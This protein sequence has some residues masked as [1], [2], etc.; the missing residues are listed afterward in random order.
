MN[1]LKSLASQTAVYGISSILA[2]LLNYLLVPLHTLLFA[3][4][5]FGPVPYFYALGAFLLIIY[6]HGMETTFF[7][8]STKSNDPKSYDYAIT[9]VIIVSLVS[10]VVLLVSADSLVS[11]AG[12]AG[13]GWLLQW[14]VVIIFIDAVTAIPFAKMR[15]ENKARKF[16]ITKVAVIAINIGL[17]LL[18]LVAAPALIKTG[19]S[20]LLSSVYNP[21]LGIGYIFLSNLTANLFLLIFLWPYFRKFTFRF[22]MATMRPMLYYALP[23]LLMG[24]AGTVS[25]QLDKILV[26]NYLDDGALGVYAQTFKLAVFIMLAIQAFRY[27]GEPFF[28]SRAKDKNAP[29]LFADVL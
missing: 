28:F 25:E 5:E 8:F 3:K 20:G 22:H 10:S 17:Q 4:D 12:Y 7:R 21:E 29:G 24:L 6:T 27:A 2:R 11:L 1:H 9:S 19:Y 14:L 18:F 15:L 26:K 13:K 16:A 23:L